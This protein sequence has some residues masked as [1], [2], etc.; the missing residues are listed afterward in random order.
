MTV[1]LIIGTVILLSL[2]L[3]LGEKKQAE[4][5]VYEDL[6]E[7]YGKK[8][9]RKEMTDERYAQVPGYYKRHLQ[10]CQIDD[11]TWNDLDMDRLFRAMDSTMSGCGEEYL[12]YL[13]RT[14][15]GKPEDLAF[16][17][18]QLSFADRD[19]E[20]RLDLQM[21]LYRLGHTGK[22]SIYDYIE[23]LDNVKIVPVWRQWMSLLLP[24]AAFG[25][26]FLSTRFGVLALIAVL[27]YNII[28]YFR[29][30]AGI[31]PY[32]VTMR[33]LLRILMVA[34]DLGRQEI[35]AFREEMG[36]MREI[37]KDFGGFRRG[38]SLLF[39]NSD[40]GSNNIID[41]LLDY[42]R[43]TL[44]LD[45]L[46]FTYML[47]DVRGRQAQVDRLI[48]I[49]GRL[50]AAVSIASW[51]RSLPYYCRPVF[52]AGAAGSEAEK[53]YHPLLAEPVANSL[54]TDR[55]VLLTGS[56]ASGKSTFLKAMALGALLGQTLRTVP[57]A[58]Y[59]ADMYQIYSSMA[60]RDDLQGGESYF[61]VEIRSLKR[62]LDAS[63][64]GGGR[65]VLCFIDEVLRGTN[66][67]ERIAASAEILGCFADRGVT[68]F[69]ATHDI[70]LTGLLQDRFENYHFQE[71]IEDGRV[72][73]HYRLLPGPSDTRNAIRL[74]ETLGY[75]AALTESAEARAQRFLRTGTWT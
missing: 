68:C 23:S 3:S 21:T 35:P 51:R 56:N 53:I 52:E 50:D 17:E 54:R 60:L 67:V 22:Y 16:T 31:D 71:D 18:E 28:T 48:T 59:R 38:A 10:E 47:R 69:A 63:G 33:Y 70:E 66:T 1:Y 24:F 72:V 61:I 27:A 73:F 39:Y 19:E 46:K 15:A 29:Q 5:D 74:L 62:I 14:P 65:P 2:A 37:I 36:E 75:D 6:K 9:R 8:A 49:L 45:L 58:A 12:Y 32:I 55:P 13:L 40:T 41:L 26:M 64:A 11:I 34:D 30:K 4:A 42:I 20:A 25:S 43:F 44:H 7:N 57:A